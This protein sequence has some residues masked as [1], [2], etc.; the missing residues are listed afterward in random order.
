MIVEKENKE[1]WAWFL[2]YLA[3]N[4][5]VH[6]D[7][8]GWTFMSNKQK[9]LVEAINGILPYVSHRHVH[10]NFKKTGFGSFSFQKK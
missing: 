8:A 1:T 9:G 7:E 2:T 10:N 3:N 6:E 5:D 4:L